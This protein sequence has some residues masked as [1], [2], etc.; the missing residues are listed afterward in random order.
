MRKSIWIEVVEW[1]VLV[2]VMLFTIGVIL[3]RSEIT[4]SAEASSTAPIESVD[5]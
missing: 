1:C 3:M 2:A 4:S 5:E